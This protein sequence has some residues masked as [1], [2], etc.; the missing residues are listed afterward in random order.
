MYSKLKI[1]GN[2]DIDFC[3]SKEKE[4]SQEEFS[5]LTNMGISEP[6]WTSDS[7]MLA[8]FNEDINGKPLGVGL[9]V[10]EY[11]IQRREVG[12]H[13]IED[14]AITQ[15]TKI[16]DWSCQSSKTY[17]YL[18]T[19]IYIDTS[20]NQILG[21]RTVSQP[22]I[23][24]WDCVS[25]IDIVETDEV[26]RYIVD[27]DNIWTFAGNVEDISYK[28]NSDVSYVN[29]YSRFPRE[30]RGKP[31]YLTASI[32]CLLGDICSVQY[33]EDNI[34]KIEAFREFC[35]NGNMKLFKDYKGN[36]L[37]CSIQSLSDTS[38]N[39]TIE[40]QTSITFE[41]VQ[42]LSRNDVSVFSEVN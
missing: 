42:L 23:T 20:G 2:C 17:E 4:L 21:R 8:Q 1:H 11:L 22:V 37:P 28:S 25:I 31:N 5:T 39:S 19:P 13:T 33:E 29:T 36:V 32:S 40:K 10:Y 38:D 3:W 41:I 34:A 27:K 15:S 35:A 24:D 7:I 6:V 26:G 18:I 30:N 9:D 14:V 16:E 12:G